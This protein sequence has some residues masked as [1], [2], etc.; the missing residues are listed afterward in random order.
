MRVQRTRS[1][2]SALRSPLTRCP[3]GAAGHACWLGVALLTLSMSVAR[4][5]DA[6]ARGP[7]VDLPAGWKCGAVPAIHVWQGDCWDQVTGATVTFVVRDIDWGWEVCEI[8]PNR[9]STEGV[10][11]G[12]RFCAEEVLDA[13]SWWIDKFAREMPDFT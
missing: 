7:L 11:F 4:A 5:E 1:S 13:R 8:E 12:T 3:L 9:Q 2:P 10:L 6:W